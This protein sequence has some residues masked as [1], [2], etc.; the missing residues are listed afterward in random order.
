LSN[1]SL[2]DVKVI[3]RQVPKVG[4]SLHLGSRLVFGPDGKLFI[5][6]GERFLFDPAQDLSNHLGK[7]LRINPDGSVPD[8]NPFIAQKD[9]QPEIWSYGHRHVQGA[10]IHPETGKLWTNEFGP[11]GG[12]EL[13]IPGA[14]ANHGW[15]TVSWGR[16]YDGRKI[17]APATHPESADAIYHWTPVISPSGM[18][19][20]TGE[21]FPDWKGNLLIAG[22]SSGGIVRL[23]VEGDKVT[24]EERIS[25]GERI[26]DVAQGPDG[27][28]FV[29]TD[30]SNGEILRLAPEKSPQ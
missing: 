1:N 6:T 15:P 26:R 4:N 11:R 5:T 18:T 8:D 12:D 19:F 14:G 13:N 10:A 17:A 22:L 9:A 3:F 28:V 24:G 25:L 20:Y 29:L 2:D 16:H 7:I 23:T 30:S 21:V 27:S